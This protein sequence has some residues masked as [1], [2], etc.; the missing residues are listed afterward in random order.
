MLGR[1]K[2]YTRQ[3]LLGMV[4]DFDKVHLLTEEDGG[5]EAVIEFLTVDMSGLLVLSN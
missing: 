1:D 3:E 5:I 4:N 2:S